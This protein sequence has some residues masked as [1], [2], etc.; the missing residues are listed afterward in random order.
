MVFLE[1]LAANSLSFRVILN[2]LSALKHYFARYSWDHQS[3]ESP[4]IS[5]MI[6]GIKLSIHKQPSPRG[7]FSLLQ[8]REISRLCEVFES[9]YTY[10]AAF[11]LA[12][13]GLLRISNI[14][15]PFQ[16]AFDKAKH[17]LRRDI[18]FQFPERMLI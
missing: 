3:I 16:K 17:F 9:S 1:F 10:R 15:P 5:R 6:R 7:L 18:R 14:A 2:Y 13:Y 12:F 11:L 4:L 8:I